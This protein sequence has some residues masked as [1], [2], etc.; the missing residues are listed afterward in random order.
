[1]LQGVFA[2]DKRQAH[3]AAGQRIAESHTGT[4]LQVIAVLDG[5][6]QV[7]GNVA[8]GFEGIHVAHQ[9]GTFRNV[10]FRAVEQGIEALIG[11]ECGRY[12]LHQF[13]IDDGEDG[14]QGRIAHEGFLKRVLLRNNAGVVRFR[15]CAC[16]S[17]DGYDRQRFYGNRLSFS[18]TDGHVIPQ[19]AFIRSHDRDSLCA[20]HDTASTQRNEKITPIVACSLCTGI[21]VAYGRIGSYTVEDAGLHTG[22]VQLLFRAGKIA[23]GAGGFTIRNNNEG[24]FARHGLFTQFVQHPCTE[25]YT[26]RDIHVVVV[27]RFHFVGYI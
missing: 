26:G 23:V 7:F 21:D 15:P 9:I 13:R 12:A 4:G 16:R 25:H 18:R 19:F 20:I 17:G 24:T 11:S 3:H 27:V 10:S 22:F 1:M 2:G 6:G 8:D 5:T 14:E